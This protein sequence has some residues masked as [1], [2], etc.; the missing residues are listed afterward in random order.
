MERHVMF[1]VAFGEVDE[2]RC[3]CGPVGPWL[4]LEY[5]FAFNLRLLSFHS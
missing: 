2:L 3:R 5:L 4:E 1:R